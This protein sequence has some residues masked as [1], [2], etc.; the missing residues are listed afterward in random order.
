[1]RERERESKRILITGKQNKECEWKQIKIKWRKRWREHRFLS[2]L[3]AG[4][5]NDN[6]EL[7][8]ELLVFVGALPGVRRNLNLEAT[9]WVNTIAREK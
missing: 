6:V 9:N 7:L 3:V 4:G 5:G 8:E 1:M 2:N